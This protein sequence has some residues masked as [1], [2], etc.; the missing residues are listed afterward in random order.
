MALKGIV[1]V[2]VDIRLEGSRDT[3]KTG[4]TVMKTK[5]QTRRLPLSYR[6]SLTQVAARGKLLRL[7]SKVALSLSRYSPLTSPTSNGV[8]PQQKFSVSSRKQP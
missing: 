1:S 8:H 2:R 4:E 7:D 5:V 6:A 3:T